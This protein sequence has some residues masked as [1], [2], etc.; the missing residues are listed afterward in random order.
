MPSVALHEFRIAKLDSPDASVTMLS[1][2]Q[3]DRVCM[4]QGVF[5]AILSRW[6]SPESDK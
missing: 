2:T 1:K 6:T 3:Y 5:T 4:E